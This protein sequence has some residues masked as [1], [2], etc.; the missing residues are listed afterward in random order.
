M[1]VP[2]NVGRPDFRRAFWNNYGSPF[3]QKMLSVLGATDLGLARSVL[4]LS[5]MATITRNI[6]GFILPSARFSIGGDNLTVFPKPPHGPGGAQVRGTQRNSA[7][8][9]AAFGRTGILPVSGKD[10]NDRQSRCS[11]WDSPT[12]QGATGL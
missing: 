9:A 7:T 12:V 2:P 4:P 5:F 10:T 1:G 3:C 6:S 8:A 11:A